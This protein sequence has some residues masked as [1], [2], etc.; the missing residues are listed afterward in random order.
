MAKKAKPGKRTPAKA[1][2]HK[3]GRKKQSAPARR[4]PSAASRQRS[5]AERLAAPLLG[6]DQRHAVGFGVSVVFIAPDR[7]LEA[8]QKELVDY[9]LQAIHDAKE[10]EA[11][12]LRALLEPDP[13]TARK[14]QEWKQSELTRLQ[15]RLKA[16]EITHKEYDADV[17]AG[18]LK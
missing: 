4:K 2:T 12:A 1:A 6:D 5:P 8:K 15:A 7:H 10:R 13:E 3:A 9:Q 18:H 17:D 14:K 11:A 16:G